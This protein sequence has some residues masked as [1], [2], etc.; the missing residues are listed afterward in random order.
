[1]TCKNCG[2]VVPDGQEIC[3]SCGAP[4][5][6][7]TPVQGAV[8]AVRKPRRKLGW[9]IALAVVVAIAA[10]VAL[11]WGYIGELI[12][13]TFSSPAD[14]YHKVETRALS[15]GT[16]ALTNPTGLAAM[17]TNL[18]GAGTA[19]TPKANQ[20]SVTLAAGDALVSLLS[21]STGTDMSW[22]KSLGLA[23]TLDGTRQ[24]LVGLNAALQ[25]N[26]ADVVNLEGMY[27]PEKYMGYFRVPELSQQY[28]SVNIEE[29]MTDYYWENGYDPTFQLM[30]ILVYGDQ[31]QYQ[32]V[33]SAIPD[34]E[35]VAALMDRYGAI[36]INNLNDVERGREEVTAEGVTCTYT[37]LTVRMDKAT[38]EKILRDVL[39][40]VA[41]DPDIKDMIVNIFRQMDEDGDEIYAS[42]RDSIQ[43][44]LD[45]EE[46]IEGDINIDMVVYV[47]DKGEIHGRDIKIVQD[48]EQELS[49][50]QIYA[51]KGSRFGTDVQVDAPE[52]FSFSVTGSGTT[53]G[54]SL[55][56]TLD[57]RFTASGKTTDLFTLDIDGTSNGGFVGKV[58][59][60]PSEE[61]ID[62]FLS[63]MDVPDEYKDLVRGMKLFLVNDSTEEHLDMKLGIIS[64]EAEFITLQ[65]E[66]HAADPLDL[67][68]PGS[69]VDVEEWAGSINQLNLMALI[70]NLQKAGIPMSFFSSLGGGLS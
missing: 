50:R 55:K 8:E 35:T 27:Q 54:D 11:S 31:S 15:T 28:A 41:N 65:A 32:S 59:L 6:N 19:E 1:M 10:G 69:A 33:M 68:V 14:Y 64:G 47:D 39:T 3:T 60:T 4:L 24:D 48:G 34:P 7:D 2:A 21:D 30:S 67:S 63:N 46:L 18:L 45:E 62:M 23:Y 36:I 58:V 29:L 51:V 9:I 42:F 22:L 53:R 66:S 37:A 20:G 61:L 26:G 44:V 25:L 57:M 70:G 56:G 17:Y 5:A 13:R 38:L 43:E 12:D 40:D 49:V 52:E 16:E